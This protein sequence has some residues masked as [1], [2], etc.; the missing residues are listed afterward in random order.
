MSKSKHWNAGGFVRLSVS[1][2]WWR[3]RIDLTTW[4][5]DIF[6]QRPTYQAFL[7]LYNSTASCKKVS[8][9]ILVRALSNNGTGLHKIIEI[10]IIII[11]I[12]SLDSIHWNPGST[13]RTLLHGKINPKDWQVAS[14]SDVAFLRFFRVVSGDYGKPWNPFG[15]W[16]IPSFHLSQISFL[17]SHLSSRRFPQEWMHQNNSGGAEHLRS[18]PREGRM[19]VWSGGNVGLGFWIMMS[20]WERWFFAL[21]FWGVNL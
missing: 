12:I 13:I 17:R 2:R 10:T 15:K 11:K 7:D 5:A 21:F 4:A 16:I 8:S 1:W 19:T 20:P 9:T 3:S 6:D 14:P 18:K